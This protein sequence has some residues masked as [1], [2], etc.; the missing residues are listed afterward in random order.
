M[1]A[2]LL[3]RL[4]LAVTCIDEFGR[5]KATSRNR[6]AYAVAPEYTY[7]YL[8]GDTK[9]T[10]Y[11]CVLET[12]RLAPLTTVE[13]IDGVSTDGLVLADKY[14]GEVTF[15]EY[16]DDN[17]DEIVRVASARKELSIDK[18]DR[19]S[20]TLVVD[21]NKANDELLD[22][23]VAKE[24]VVT[25]SGKKAWF[26]CDDNAEFESL[27]APIFT[28]V[29]DEEFV[30]TGCYKTYM[31]VDTNKNKKDAKPFFEKKEVYIITCNQ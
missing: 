24:S 1:N 21:A 11:S 12:G 2:K 6:F 3:G 25:I 7:L 13:V 5:Q 8:V 28:D 4:A 10:A 16:L 15:D 31:Q 23:L 17:T 26:A 29:T 9:Y 19:E 14:T 18:K 20:F 27:G 30:V 22:Y